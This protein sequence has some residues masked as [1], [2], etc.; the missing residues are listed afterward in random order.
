MKWFGLFLLSF[1][2]LGCVQPGPPL[3]SPT[4]SPGGSQL[5][6][7][8]AVHCAALGYENKIADG[9]GGQYGV[10]VFPDGSSC[11]DWA[12]LRGECGQA[13]SACAKSGGRLGGVL[14][15]P[16]GPVTSNST[17]QFSDG[18]IC[19]ESDLA[20]GSCKPAQQLP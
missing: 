14:M 20:S 2:A 15:G 18:S 10:C 1:L 7:P 11:D 19:E 13:F 9:A 16:N 5:A 17:C 12:F 6:N 8:A 4:P 3:A